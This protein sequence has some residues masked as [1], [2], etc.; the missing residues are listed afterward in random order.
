VGLARAVPARCLGRGVRPVS[1]LAP[2]GNTELRVV[3]QFEY[4]PS[5]P[6]ISSI[7]VGCY[8]PSHEASRRYACE[9]SSCLDAGASR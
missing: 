5:S 1:A 7:A 8:D 4:I 9:N 6:S 2:A 3:G